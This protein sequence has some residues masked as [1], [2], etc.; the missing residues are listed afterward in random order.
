MKIT[1]TTT[2]TEI[3]QLTAYLP[4]L[5]ADGYEPIK[6]WHGG[7]KSKDGVIQLPYPD[8]D[9]AVIQFFRLASKDFWLD[10]QYN[11]QEAELTLTNEKAV[12]SA[13]LEEIKTLV[14]YCV[15]G[16]RFCDGHWGAMIEQGYVRQILERLIVIRKQ[17]GENPE[18]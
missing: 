2:L 12:A 16:E 3:D 18:A 1:S 11:P 17:L 13:T 5:Y 7:V 14:T 15:R 4:I 10:Y 6:E 9:E 8:Y